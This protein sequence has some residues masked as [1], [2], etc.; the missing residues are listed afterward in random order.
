MRRATVKFCCVK[1]RSN[2]R[3]IEACGFTLI[4]LLVVMAIISLLMSILI[5]AVTKVR[6]QAKKM[7]SVNNQRQI[8]TILNCFAMD[9]DNRYPKS[10]ATIVA[11]DNSWGWQEP[12][13]LIASKSLGNGTARSLSSYLRSYIEKASMIFCP[14]A[15]EG[16]E[17]LQQA[18]DA[19]DDW[20]NPDTAPAR[21]PLMGSYCFY[22]NY[23]GYLGGSRGTFKG[24]QTPMD[25]RGRS[26]LLVSDYFGY[27]HW[28]SP[29]S[30]G[31]CEKFRKGTSVTSGT[32]VSSSYWSYACGDD[33]AKNQQVLSNVKVK[34]HAGYIDGHVE[35]FFTADAVPMR[36]STKPDGSVPYPDGVGLGPGVFYIPTN[37]LP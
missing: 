8:V 29:K 18:W 37:G 25:G 9:N 10:V 22:W 26:R 1:G 5:P 2:R 4:E 3:L 11:S 12:T 6:V 13:M 27:D 34:L 33:D 24:P 31:S 19:G 20:D 7:E 14:S 30:F 16:Y 21:D 35:D 28:R 15:P 36:V 23:T 32:R 17:Y